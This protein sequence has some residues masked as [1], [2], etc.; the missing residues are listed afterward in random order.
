MMGTSTWSLG[1]SG[2]AHYLMLVVVRHAARKL[3]YHIDDLVVPRG[4]NIA[5]RVVESLNLV[6]EDSRE[7]MTAH[8]QHSGDPTHGLHHLAG[9]YMVVEH[10]RPQGSIS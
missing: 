8:S 4:K 2:I 1:S 3:S 6:S 9:T 5:T 7:P 10:V